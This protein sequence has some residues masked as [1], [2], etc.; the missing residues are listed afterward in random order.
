LEKRIKRNPASFVK[1]ALE[2]AMVKRLE[3][4]GIA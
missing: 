2:K 4:D 3:E 1:E